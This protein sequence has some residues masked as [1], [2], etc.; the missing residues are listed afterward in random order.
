MNTPKS[1]GDKEKKKKKKNKEDKE[2]NGG[3]RIKRPQS[4][5]MLY[6]NHRR[7]TLMK[8]YPGTHIL[9]HTY[10]SQ[11]ARSLKDGRGRVE[12]AFR[13]SEKGKLRQ[14]FRPN[15]KLKI[16]IFNYKLT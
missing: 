16:A 3:E 1:K 8:E 14:G 13:R 12:K 4:A 11:I 6:N 15:E 9:F 2:Q 7:P 5:F 10:R